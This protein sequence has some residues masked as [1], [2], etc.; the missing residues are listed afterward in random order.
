MKNIQA[1]EH[2]LTEEILPKLLK[3]DGIKV[4]GPQ[5]PNKHTATFAF[6]LKGIHPHDVAT[7]LDMN[8]IAVRA[9]HHC[10]QPLMDYLNLTATARA[11]FY[12]YNTV[13]EGNKLVDSLEQVKEFFS[14]GVSETK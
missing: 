9:G 2:D 6:N 11:S 7:A 8:G 1:Y 14:N 12:F 13:D 10:A 5:D 4:Y 3:I